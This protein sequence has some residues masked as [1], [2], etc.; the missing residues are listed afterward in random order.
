VCREKR[1]AAL[2][3]VEEVERLRQDEV[4]I[5]GIA[6][7]RLVVDDDCMLRELLK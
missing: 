1:D 3:T 2:S 7:K 4:M 6:V 5:E